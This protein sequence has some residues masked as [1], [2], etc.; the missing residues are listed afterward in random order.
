MAK[1]SPSKGATIIEPISSSFDTPF[2]LS[3][4][5]YATKVDDVP[6]VDFK[7]QLV[8]GFWVS[9]IKIEIVDPRV[10]DVDCRIS[11]MKGAKE[12][13]L[14]QCNLK[15]QNQSVYVLQLSSVWDFPTGSFLRIKCKGPETGWQS[16][17]PRAT[18]SGGPLK[19]NRPDL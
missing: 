8:P 5:S 13:V 17:V 2:P 14:F 1:P 12:E 15:R 7:S 6:P 16:R 18:V 19:E 11:L 3:D 9:A 4:Y 10:H